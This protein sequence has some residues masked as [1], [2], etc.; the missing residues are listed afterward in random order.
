MPN[1]SL[2]GADS[3]PALVVAPTRVNLGRSRRIDLAVGP[4]PI[5][6]SIAKS[7]I[8]GYSTSSTWR[9]ILWI[10]STNRIS[11]S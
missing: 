5:M 6:M 4:L 8:A 10:S 1:L 7:S 9:D 3:I 2:R 11:P